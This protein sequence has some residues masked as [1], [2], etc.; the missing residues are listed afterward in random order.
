MCNQNKLLKEF[1]NKGDIFA[2]EAGI[3]LKEICDGKAVAE[4]TV[5]AQH[6]NAG[7]VCQGGALFTLADLAIAGVMNSHGKLSFSIQ[8]SITF[9]HSALVGD[10]LTAI[11]TEVENHHKLPCCE[12]KVTNQ[13]GKLICSLTAIAYRK[14]KPIP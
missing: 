5:G 14:D 10:H 7:G 1:L 9:V 12:V 6:L 11:A 3:S 13:E 4:M 2:A 8:T